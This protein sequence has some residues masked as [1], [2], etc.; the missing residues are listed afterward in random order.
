M[1]EI[2]GCLRD[3]SIPMA[4]MSVEPAKPEEVRTTNTVDN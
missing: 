1:F 3:K 4:S 2:V